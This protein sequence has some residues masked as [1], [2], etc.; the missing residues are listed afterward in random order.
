MRRAAFSVVLVALAAGCGGSEAAAPTG[1]ATQPPE[2]A[3]TEPEPE[4]TNGLVVYLLRDGRV[5]PAHREVPQTAAVGTAAIEALLAGP[6]AEEESLGATSALPAGASL[7]ELTVADGT[8]A[9]DLSEGE[10]SEAA[11]A[12]LTFTLT[13]FP[14]IKAVWVGVRGEPIGPQDHPLTRGDFP[15]LTPIILVEHPALGETV[16]SPVRVSGTASVF[17]ATLRVRLIGP[18]GMTLRDETVTASEGAPGRGTFSVEIPFA[19]S[20]PGQ[21]EAYTISAADSSEQHNFAVAVELAP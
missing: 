1:P 21:V 3:A 13:Q 16:S 19:A 2:T 4:A 14:T 18:D 9:V 17:E 7:L 12:Q 6:T 5:A 15:D 10:L 8:A 11:L 20:G